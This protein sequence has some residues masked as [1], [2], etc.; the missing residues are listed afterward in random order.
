MSKAYWTA[1]IAY[2]GTAQ[3]ASVFIKTR[4]D[5]ATFATYSAVM[6]RPKLDG[7]VT[8]GLRSWRDVTFRFTMLVLQ[9]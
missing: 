6:H 7:E 3:S 9:V 8:W 4:K 1:M 2:L 5:D